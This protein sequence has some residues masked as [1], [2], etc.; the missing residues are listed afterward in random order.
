M[1]STTGCCVCAEDPDDRDPEG[2]EAAVGRVVPAEAEVDGALGDG[3][4]E[5]AAAA[6]AAVDALG[7][8]AAVAAAAA[9]A[10]CS[11]SDGIPRRLAIWFSICSRISQRIFT[12]SAFSGSSCCTCH[13]CKDRE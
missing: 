7:L 4:D 8:V 1:F 12:S 9:A 11:L 3:F 13:V 10:A 5:S 6:T 2:P